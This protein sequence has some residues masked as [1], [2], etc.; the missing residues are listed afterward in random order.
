MYGESF[1]HIRN[2]M[3]HWEANEAQFKTVVASGKFFF[4]NFGPCPAGLRFMI[5]GVA[6][7]S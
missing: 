5:G 6:C 7:S 2:V 1:S 3:L 4:V